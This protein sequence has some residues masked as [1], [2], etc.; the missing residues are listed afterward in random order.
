M[1]FM[2]FEKRI[3]LAEVLSV[4]R[5]NTLS[6]YF[7]FRAAV[8]S[9]AFGILGVYVFPERKRFDSDKMQIVEP[10][11]YWE[12]AVWFHCQPPLF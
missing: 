4:T 11:S 2:I 3:M 8:Y 6:R 1:I 12:D 5:I 9:P 7:L 10:R